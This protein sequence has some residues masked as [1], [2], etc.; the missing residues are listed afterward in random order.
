MGRAAHAT[1]TYG[2]PAN[3]L[4]RLWIPQRIDASHA[5]GLHI[6]RD[7]RVAPEARGNQRRHGVRSRNRVRWLHVSAAAARFCADCGAVIRLVPEPERP[8][9]AEAAASRSPISGSLSVGSPDHAAGVPAARVWNPLRTFPRSSPRRNYGS[10][11]SLRAKE[12]ST[13]VPSGH[14][15]CGRCGAVVPPAILELRTEFFGAMQ[16]PGK[17]RLI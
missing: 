14:K 2:G 16:A 3:A 9:E 13:P 6:D 1:P 17:A 8:R 7:F 12:C 10:G 15:F 5:Y 11:A 4:F